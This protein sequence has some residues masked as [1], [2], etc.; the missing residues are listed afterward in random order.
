MRW[1]I[2]EP[3]KQCQ[4]TG[5]SCIH[6]SNPDGLSL[7]L[8]FKNQERK[9][10]QNNTGELNASQA[11]RLLCSVTLIP[12]LLNKLNPSLFVCFKVAVKLLN[13]L[14]MTV[15]T[16]WKPTSCE[17]KWSWYTVSINCICFCCKICEVLFL[18]FPQQF[19]LILTE[20]IRCNRW[21]ITV[22]CLF[23]FLVPLFGWQKYFRHKSFFRES[24]GNEKMEQNA[25]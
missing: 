22:I 9:R 20:V 8:S 1:I 25:G 24:V 6:S 11:K 13:Q 12:Y 16:K 23:P 3:W 4:G 14:T 17:G 10:K 18:F 2:I 7:F 15:Y 21:S 5:L 19:K